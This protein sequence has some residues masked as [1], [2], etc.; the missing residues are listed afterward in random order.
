M[1]TK[2]SFGILFFGIIWMCITNVDAQLPNRV[3]HMQGTA[4][5]NGIEVTV[6][7]VGEINTSG[8]EYY[9]DGQTGPYYFGLDY[10]RRYGN[11]EFSFSPPISHVTIDFTG[12]TGDSENMEEMQVF[13]NG[14]HYAIP[15]PGKKLCEDL[16]VLTS[17]GNIRPCRDCGVS[18]WKGTRIE[19]PIE[20]LTISDTILHGT[21]GG[22]LFALYIGDP[23]PENNDEYTAVK[24]IKAGDI[25]AGK[26][27]LI[28]STLIATAT[29]SLKDK[30]ENI[31]SLEYFKINDE[32]IYVDARLLIKGTYVLDI[33]S[34][35]QVEKQKLVIE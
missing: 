25:A 18:G 19:G 35:E 9:C 8:V 1:M 10:E 26:G 3:K 28:T 17:K 29:L 13:I 11:F 15:E 4:T 5:V 2:P 30:F 33:V 27:I 12:L 34:G 24:K 32:Q 20:K 22:V 16:A 23:V 7:H 21:P 14:E 6:T 31:V